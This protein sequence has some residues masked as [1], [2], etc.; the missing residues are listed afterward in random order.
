MYQLKT[1]RNKALVM[2]RL[3][4]LKLKNDVPV[5]EHTSEFKNLMNQLATVKMP[6]DDEMQAVLLFNSLPDSWET[7]VVSF[8]N[9]APEGKLTMN[10]VIDA[11][12]NEKTMMK[13]MG[14][15]QSHA[16]VTEVRG[17]DRGRER[18]R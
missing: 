10:M 16:L 14:G 18:G 5:T 8:S 6:L 7:L 13:D 4:N 2:R 12:Y 15:N 3:V 9:S 11:M 17:R 1:A